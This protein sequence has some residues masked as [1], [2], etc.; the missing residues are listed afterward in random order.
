[1]KHRFIPEHVQFITENIIGHS[2]KEL[3]EMFNCHFG[4]E[5]GLNQ[6]TAFIKNNK[7]TS[8]VDCT[9]KPGSVPFNKGKKGIGGWEPTQFKKG[10]RPLNYRPVGSQRVNVDGYIEIKIADPAAWRPKHTVLWEEVHGPVPKGCCL[11]FLDNDRLN[12][13]LD[14][15]QLITRKQL[16]RLNQNN[17]ISN[18]A[19]LTKTGIIL[20]DVYQKIG[21]RKKAK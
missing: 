2:R 13:S 19:D 1:M 3:T 21:E 6:I 16:V 14:N 12:I 5:L 11:L 4:L 9:Y 8:G 18:D 7:L 20:A 15:L 17:L 10:N